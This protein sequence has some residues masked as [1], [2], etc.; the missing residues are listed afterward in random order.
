[1]LKFARLCFPKKLFK[2]PVSCLN[3]TLKRNIKAQQNI[4]TKAIE[5]DTEVKS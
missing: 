1:M 2:K 3:C 5:L 4:F